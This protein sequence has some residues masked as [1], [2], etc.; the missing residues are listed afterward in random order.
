VKGGTAVATLFI[1]ACIIGCSPG[2][3]SG[4]GI[5]LTIFAA[6]SLEPALEKVVDAY[7]T[8]NPGVV[9]TISTDSSAALEAK[10]EQGARADIFLSADTSNPQKLV[11]AGL[12]AGDPV[13]FA[14][15][16]LAVIVPTAN[17][18]G[19]ASPIDLAKPGLKIIAAHGSVPISKY[20]AQL[21]ANLAR[22]PGYP[23]GFA[24]AYAANIAS[25]EDNVAGIVSKIELGEGD[26]GIVYATDARTSTKIRMVDVPLSANVP[27]TYAGVVVTA[28]PNQPAAEAL[29]SWLTSADGRAVFAEFGFLPPG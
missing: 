16:E 22:L 23:A 6:A 18:A 21:V 11:D 7:S 20:A 3:S 14:R 4:K 2:T 19:V 26:A 25:E 27:A 24:T 17:P 28:T 5:S 13:P 29:L 15:N 12:A 8:V 10:I 1:V 9:L